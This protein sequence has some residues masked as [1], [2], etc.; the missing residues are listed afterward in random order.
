[1]DFHNDCVDTGSVPEH[2]LRSRAASML[3]SVTLVSSLVYGFRL[4]AVLHKVFRQVSICI[5]GH[6]GSTAVYYM[7]YVVLSFDKVNS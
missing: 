3:T 6:G 1:M 5:S 2:G 4:H 7:Y